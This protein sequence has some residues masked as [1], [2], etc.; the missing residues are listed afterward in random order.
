MS[1]CLFLTLFPPISLLLFF[2]FFLLQSQEYCRSC[3]LFIVL[4]V[5][6]RCDSGGDCECL[7]TA[8]AAYAEECNRRGV[9]IRWRSQELCRMLRHSTSSHITCTATVVFLSYCKFCLLCVGTVVHSVSVFFP[10]AL[11]C[12]NGLVYDPCGPACSTS[13]PSI[14]H[15]PQSQCS[16]LSCVEGCFCPAGTV[17]LGKNQLP[18]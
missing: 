2:F 10:A 6:L 1:V 17:W 9:Y 14:Q 3:V 15:S 11:Q 12:E 5:C 16:T 18:H 13:C 7:C 4:Y 8:I